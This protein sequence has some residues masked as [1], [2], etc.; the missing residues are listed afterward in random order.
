MNHILF[1][2]LAAMLL[3]AFVAGL[4][5]GIRKGVHSKQWAMPVGLAGAALI[6][7]LALWGTGSSRRSVP[8]I[9][10][11][12]PDNF[13]LQEDKSGNYPDYIELHNP[14]SLPVDL[15][16]F[17]LSDDLDDLS[18]FPLPDISLDPGAYILI[19]AD[20]S[21]SLREG[22]IYANFRLAPGET[23]FLSHIEQGLLQSLAA[24]VYTA[25][26]TVS[27]VSGSYV[28]AYGTPGRSNEGAALYKAPTLSAPGFSLPS[29]FYPEDSVTVEL[30]CPYTV[31]YT[32]DGSTPD[33]N[34]PVYTAPLRLTDPSST[35]NRYVNLPNTT[36][37]YTGSKDREDPVNKAN[38]IRAV[39]TDEKGNFSPVV[40]A[41]YFV[42]QAAQSYADAWVLSVVSDPEGLFGDEGICVTGK[43]Y[44]LWYA[45][46]DDAAS[47]PT[48][49]FE[50]K[51]RQWERPAHIQLWDGNGSL[52]LDQACGIRVQGN[53]YRSFATKRFTFYARPQYGGSELFEASVFPSGELSHAFSTR[54]DHA[55]MIAQALIGDRELSCQ[56]GV[57]VVCFLDGEFYAST[58]LRQRTDSAFF[59][60]RY[61][62]QEDSVAIIEQ[63]TLDEGTEKDLADYRAL[64]E[65]MTSGDTTD[66][67]VYGEIQKRI[68]LQS[69]TDFVCATLYTNN[70][71]V[72]T[73][74]NFKLWRVSGGAGTGY[75]D[76]RWRA[77]AYDMDAVTWAYRVRTKDSF[78]T[79][80][81]FAYCIE[82][83]EKYGSG[84]R[85]LIHL[86]FLKNL[87][88]NEDYRRQFVS[89]YLD[90][91]NTNF[92]QQSRG[93][94]V[95][96]HYPAAQPR[97]WPVFLTRR[98]GFALEHLKNALDITQPN[99][100]VT[101]VTQ[102]EG[103]VQ[104]N[105]TYA[106]TGSDAWTGTYISGMEIRLTAQA[107]EG[108][109]FA[110]WEGGLSS[111]DAEQSLILDENG[112][113]VTAVFL[114]AGS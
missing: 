45:R 24:N 76:G 74:R 93:G 111:P 72:S 29:G 85:F 19:Y 21:G 66:P 56:E 8:V 49:N 14:G 114:P 30:H 82:D 35:P 108:W 12:C 89:T 38:I 43:E 113:S 60:Q 101:L 22:D 91:M 33:E 78:L 97:F 9:S 54:S 31:H 102:G 44:D 86:P 106:D 104:I 71:D 37:S 5:L 10:E 13:A 48:P 67:A 62:V 53:S 70:L 80:D 83:Q 23:V 7:L 84:Q 2:L 20:G 109:V 94:Q 63:N 110:G 77:V 58:Y 65:L 92:S 61:G 79:L 112:L 87:L 42:G 34:S 25:D 107:E 64:M 16:E 17:C 103:S 36:A 39:A 46:Q 1:W 88:K 26:V 11:L 55:D 52:V 100:T 47:R 99:C 28:A 27:S 75:N 3:G 6:L 40:T 41:T 57:A 69:L 51:G 95:I 105:T 32:T 59:A 90:M 81:P 18:Q 96:A 4:F 68:D 98:Q 73:A 15:G 50:Q